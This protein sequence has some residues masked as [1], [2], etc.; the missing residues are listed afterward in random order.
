MKRIDLIG[1]QEL[2]L[3]RNDSKDAVNGSSSGVEAVRSNRYPQIII[4][5]DSCEL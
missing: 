5:N 4:N 2:E 1:T 3:Q